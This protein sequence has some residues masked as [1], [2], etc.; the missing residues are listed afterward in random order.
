[1]PLALRLQVA[2]SLAGVAAVVAATAGGVTGV[3]LGPTAGVVA[4]TPVVVAT[5][6]LLVRIMR[7]SVRVD[8]EELVV[9]NVLHDRWVRRHPRVRIH[10]QGSVLRR[11]AIE[12]EGDVVPV[13][14]S[15]SIGQPINEHTQRI[16]RT[17][18]RW[19]G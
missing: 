15:L 16:R 4:G 19:S 7:V 12:G 10:E 2:S 18:L 8:A 9:C 11:L 1:M 14:A 3:A 6:W 17:L 5:A 13:T